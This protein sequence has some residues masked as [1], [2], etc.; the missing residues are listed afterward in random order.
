M[1]ED[2]LGHAHP[3]FGSLAEG[4][5]NGELGHRRSVIG[6]TGCA[7]SRVSAAPARA[8]H[9]VLGLARDLDSPAARQL[10][11]AEA[12]PV[13]GDF[14]R[15]ETWRAHLNGVDAV[16]H[17]LMDMSDPHGAG[18]RL[19]AELAAA[20]DRDGRRRHLVRILDGPT[21]VDGQT[22]VIAADRRLRALDIQPWQAA[23]PGN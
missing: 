8:G 21:A 13:Q 20:Q 1:I 22:F 10:T 15:P 23:Q 18:Q 19:F 16:V 9:T 12:T 11:I 5:Q 6:A 2:S 7:G 17:L 14:S 4:E 3:A